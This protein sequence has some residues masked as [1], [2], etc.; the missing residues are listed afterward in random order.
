MTKDTGWPAIPQDQP[1]TQTEN[2]MIA[3]IIRSAFIDRRGVT[4]AEYAVMAVALVA[5][6]GA[7]VAAFA[8]RLLAAMSG[9]LPA[10]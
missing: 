10:A 7:G 5:A 4:A 3:P 2:I 9:L 1:A 8:P 6:V